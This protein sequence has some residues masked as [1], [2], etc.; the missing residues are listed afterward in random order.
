MALVAG[1]VW[2]SWAA[3][4]RAQELVLPPL[5]HH[6]E[7]VWTDDAGLLVTGDER[8]AVWDLAGTPLSDAVFV[9][10]VVDADGAGVGADAVAVVAGANGELARW[11]NGAWERDVAL[12]EGDAHVVAVA[13]AEG[14]AAWIADDRWAVH[15][16]R[17]GG[18]ARA[19][20]YADAADPVV[21]V[22][23]RA[24]GAGGA[25]LLHRSGAL[26]AVVERPA[27][28]GAPP[29]F[30]IEALAP[31]P[32]DAPTAGWVAAWSGPGGEGDGAEPWR[33]HA[34]G[35]LLG[36]GGA[37]EALP[38]SGCTTLD[39][40]RV[41]GR[42]ILAVGCSR[43]IFLYDGEDVWVADDRIGIPTALAL[44]P[45]LGVVLAVDNLGLSAPIAGHP[46]LVADAARPI[47]VDP[48]MWFGPS[49]R[50]GVVAHRFDA[51][52]YAS[53][54]ALDAGV[55]GFV[56]L[57]PTRWSFGLWPS[58]GYSHD[59]APP[60]DGDGGGGGGRPRT[61]NY[62]ALGFG[63][64]VG[65]DALA[66]AYR[67]ELL[68]GRAAGEPA[69]GVRHGVWAQAFEGIVGLELSHQLV[70][71]DAGRLPAFRVLVGVNWSNLVRAVAPRSTWE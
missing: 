30:A 66:L 17:P 14:G 13:V 56:G 67:A 59:A 3:P 40:A 61:A 33:L 65:S 29:R 24:A 63:P 69:L 43:R 62:F 41:A 9:R 18:M 46:L 55:D 38:A 11:R 36:P 19:I 71:V 32:A 68:A 7:V 53:A 50:T 70:Y 4:A 28:D 58:I 26:S 27:E 35:L 10:D 21:D 15:L 25:Y 16:W 48:P 39:G 45:T 1:A 51:G 5:G 34:D 60:N 23:S 44:A 47:A 22:T 52:E 57:S 8:V 31:P 54:W 20:P 64:G 49:V 42:V 6:V 37:R 12:V 2:A